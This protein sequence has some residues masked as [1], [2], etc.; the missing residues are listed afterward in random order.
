M[1]RERAIE[2]AHRRNYDCRGIIMSKAKSASQFISYSLLCTPR[3][4]G[5]GR[6]LA[7]ELRVRLKETIESFAVD[8]NADH[9]AIRLK[10]CR[11]LSDGEIRATFA[12]PGTMESGFTEYLYDRTDVLDIDILEAGED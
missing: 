9:L 8:R 12:M 7:S 4:D 3:K 10:S 1:K 2:Q 11:Y 5:D 6:K